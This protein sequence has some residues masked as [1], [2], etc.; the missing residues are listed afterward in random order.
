MNLIKN[1][2]Y[3]KNINNHKVIHFFGIKIKI[4]NKKLTDYNLIVKRNL[5][6]IKISI[7]NNYKNPACHYSAFALDNA[8]DNILVASLQKS[9]NM[10]LVN[11]FEFINEPVRD[12]LTDD[13]IYLINKCKAMI[14]GG[15][16]LFLK[17]TN[18]NDISGWQF[19]ISCEQ[20]DKIKTP[21]YIFG[22]GYNRFRNQEDF[23]P[24]FKLNIN[25]IVEKAKFVGIR[26]NGSI[27]ALKTYL[28]DEL[29]EKLKFHPC[30]TTILSKI[31]KIPQ[32]KEKPFVAVNCAFDREHLRYGEKKEEILNSIAK[33]IKKLSLDYEIRYYSHLST[34]KNILP[35]FDKY[36]IDY[37]IV[38][39]DTALTEQDFLRLYSTPKLVIG[40]RGH[41]Q[42][43]PFGCGTPILSI[44]THNKLTWF[45]EDINH[46][47]WGG[48]ITK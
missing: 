13:D 23:D 17:D 41:A 10:N 47:E 46:P 22:V 38:N 35:Y 45:L 28:R 14:I 44:I 4:K 6:P 11:K 34:D 20:I 8:G 37:S 18:K 33:V 31:Y 7:I 48:G 39:L 36:Q 5:F 25:K 12:T 2:I 29:K 30:A 27:K 19:P 9:I 1:L 32:I 3:S 26:N 16:G 42:M 40:M 24:I 43:I 15:G 21:I